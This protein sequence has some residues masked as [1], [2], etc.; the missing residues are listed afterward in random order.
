V[1]T[2]KKELDNTLLFRA[3]RLLQRADK[4][5]LVAITLVQ[6]LLG[7]LDILSVAII[8]LLTAISVNGI[9][10]KSTTSE[11]LE[12]IPFVSFND[13]SF[14]TRV[15]LLGTLAAAL[16]V[17]RTLLSMY[18]SRRILF[19]LSRRGASISSSLISKVLGQN[20]NSVQ[21]N[22]SQKIIYSVT[23]GVSS[24][25]LGVIG[26]SAA[27]IADS[28]LL[29]FM[30]ITLFIYDPMM[31]ILTTTIFAGIGLVLYLL[32]HVRIKALGEKNAEL[33]ITSNEQIMEV[34]SSFRESFVRNRRAH[35][36]NN[37]S[38]VRQQLA[39]AN[40]EMSFM[41]NISKY[42][43]EIAL[44][45]GAVLIAASQFLTTDAVNAISAMTVFMAASTRIVPAVLRIQ[46]GVLGIK[47]SAGAAKPTL[48]MIEEVM[49]SSD[50][51]FGDSSIDFSHEGFSP[52]VTVRDLEFSYDETKVIKGINIDIYPGEKV[53]L[54]GGSGAGKSTLMDLIIGVLAPNVGSVKISGKDPV[55][56]IRDWQGAIAYVPQNISLIDGTIADNIRLG[57]PKEIVSDS[58]ILEAIKTAQLED[59]VNDLPSGIETL[60]GE[61][62]SRLSGGQKQRVGIARALVTKPMLIFMDEA[63]SALE[64]KT[65]QKISDTL[66]SL[67]KSI[68]VILI[69][70]RITTIQYADKII[71][72]ENGQIIA[73]GS[74]EKV[75]E[76][77]P[78]FNE[79]MSK[80][81][82]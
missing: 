42:V 27:L 51:P 24:V 73:S 65:E 23:S 57:F 7:V 22:S 19:F 33:T 67:D 2:S 39:N 41:P 56:A 28:S 8:G 47:G 16:L 6:V 81:V 61:G 35:Y 68:S 43:L 62:G 70:H 13:F 78:A 59:F 77:V 9:Q 55:D 11:I 1:I 58:R 15:A 45:V 38:E 21:K 46:Q 29:I 49:N 30:S 75:R 40:A 12:M 63:T 50:L 31:A 10:S 26:S 36:A 66:A 53:A 48:H 82:I 64:S 52:T 54:V 79:A 4:Y 80:L 74:V 44:V 37:I 3:L 17:T 72:M 34:L 69:A 18:I 71:Y 32:M 25:T 60:V 5:K 76:V 20:L 14:Q